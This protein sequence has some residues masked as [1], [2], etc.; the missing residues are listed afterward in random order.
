MSRRQSLLSGRRAFTLI[1]LLTVIA[2]IG[3]LA[4][5]I[6][7][8]VGGVR[9]NAR[10]S[11]AASN[12]RQIALAHAAYT[13]SSARPRS[14]N[15]NDIYDWARILAENGHFNDPQI[16][17]LNEDPLV[18]Q[19]NLPYPQ[20]VASPP[21]SNS[22]AWT[23]D[24]SFQGFPLSFVVVNRLPSQA[25]ASTTPLAWTRGLQPS[26]QWAPFDAT[27]P[28]VYGSDGGH[29]VFLDGNVRYYRDLAEDG[30]QLIHYLT[31]RPTAL[32]T[33]ALPPGAIALDFTGPAF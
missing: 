23:V 12:L 25:P 29:I 22:G 15:A 1:E 32:I 24:A 2:V 10:R 8:T 14:I 7:P 26:G 30:G 13:G 20:V 31:K 11:V 27:N 18:E 3:I 4:A 21:A 9:E 28:G 6:I 33:E 5:I 17:F 19:S 16:Y